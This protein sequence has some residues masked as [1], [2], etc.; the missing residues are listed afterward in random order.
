[1]VRCGIVGVGKM[2]EALLKGLLKLQSQGEIEIL[3]YEVSRERREEIEERYR[4]K[5]E[6]S[7]I[8]LL[9]RCDALFLAVKPQQMGDLL[10]EMGRWT[11]GKLLISIAAG[12]S[13]DTLRRGASSQTKVVR[14]M[15]NT[16]ALLGEGAIAYAL[17]PGCG[18][19]EKA[20]VER[21]L[22]PLGMVVEVKEAL[23]NAI[24]ALSG[25]GP[26]YVFLMVEA[27]TDA[28]V[29]VGIPRD[30]SLK[31]TL[32]TL[33]GSLK[34]MNAVGKHAAE[35]IDMVTSPGGTTIV[36]LHQMEK[37]GFKGIVMDAVKAAEERARELEKI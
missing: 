19:K 14:V 35:M 30:L 2:G 23:M 24:T 29:R 36:A 3:G 13:L 15:P 17:G 34:L 21:L 11:D 1:M 26:A 7:L 16:P 22:S 6:D 4:M 20:L 8:T 28:G 18:P 32:K 5:L 37:A 10:D 31:L 33:D 27:L 9:R 25:S 12:I